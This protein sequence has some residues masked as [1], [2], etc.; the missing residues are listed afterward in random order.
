[1]LVNQQETSQL[2]SRCRVYKRQLLTRVSQRR[3]LFYK[4]HP[5]PLFRVRYRSVVRCQESKCCET[6]FYAKIGEEYLI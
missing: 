3:R 6:V 4:R 2:E 5:Q 1:M